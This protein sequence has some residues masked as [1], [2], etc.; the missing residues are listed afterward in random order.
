MTDIQPSVC[1]GV[2]QQVMVAHLAE[3]MCVYLED[4]F[5]VQP[6]SMRPTSPNLEVLEHEHTIIEINCQQ[7]FPWSHLVPAFCNYLYLDRVGS[8]I[9]DVKGW[10]PYCVRRLLIDIQSLQNS[11]IHLLHCQSQAPFEVILCEKMFVNWQFLFFPH[12]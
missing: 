10:C 3:S 7:M 12:L 2:W 5:Q 4:C 6:S 11:I 8:V 1:N 9:C